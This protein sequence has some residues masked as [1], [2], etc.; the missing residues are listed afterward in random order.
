[1]R[2]KKV[3][4]SAKKN[5]PLKNQSGGKPS[6]KKRQ[7][8]K[9]GLKSKT[10]KSAGKAAGF[11]QLNKDKWPIERDVLF[12]PDR[13]KYVRKLIKDEGCVFCKAAKEPP[14]LETLCVYQSE[15]SMIVLNK[16]PYNS[17]HVLILPKRHIGSLLDLQPAEY[18]DL[19]KTIR[20]AMS[21]LQQVYN[22]GG[23]NLGLNHGAVAGAGIPDHLHYHIV[24]RWSGDLNFF[25]LVA[26][27]K[28]VVESLE[29]SFDRLLAY[30]K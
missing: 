3:M 19:N 30:F 16:F 12:R 14:T 18:D 25:P 10:A 20:L 26:E 17:G 22:P 7:A 8:K 1:M 21:A 9:S 24:P 29:A 5:Q 13:L 15:Y 27:T 23:M 6:A 28:V 2:K 11:I 4:A